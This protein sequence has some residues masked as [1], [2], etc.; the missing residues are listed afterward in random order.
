[1]GFMHADRA[2]AP[3]ALIYGPTAPVKLEHAGPP[4]AEVDA[5]GP[6]DAVT[7]SRATE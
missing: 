7:A 2:A 1:M 6:R 5:P 3:G 4:S